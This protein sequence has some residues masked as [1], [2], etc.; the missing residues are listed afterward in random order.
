LDAMATGNATSIWTPLV[1]FLN[2]NNLQ[3]S[4]FS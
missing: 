1:G 4:S 2:P 3:E